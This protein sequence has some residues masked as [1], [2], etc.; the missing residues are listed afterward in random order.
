MDLLL[1]ASFR[2]VLNSLD[3]R[4]ALA[5]LIENTGAAWGE[6]YASSL[7]DMAWLEGRRSMGAKMMKLIKDCDPEAAREI[8]N[9][10]WEIRNGRYDTASQ[11]SAS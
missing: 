2:R 11:P 4:K 9:L 5:L 8:N 7:I 10:I 6:T 1:E 3:G